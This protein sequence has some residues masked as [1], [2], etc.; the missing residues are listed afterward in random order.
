MIAEHYYDKWSP[1]GPPL[2]LPPIIIS[3]I[4][5]PEEVK[6][7]RALLERARKYDRDN[8][9]P[10][11]ESHDK[12]ERLTR[13]LNEFDLDESIRKEILDLVKG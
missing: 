5:S 8:N 12:I 4:I 9:Q 7:F 2:N 10:D 11:C 1:Q 6:E 13:L 3:P